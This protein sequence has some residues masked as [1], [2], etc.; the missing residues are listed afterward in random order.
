MTKTARHTLKAAA[1]LALAA[2]KV[3][4]LARKQHQWRQ[5]D[6]AERLGV[7]RQTVARLERGDPS[8]AVGVFL[9]ALWLLDLPLTEGRELPT[10]SLLKLIEQQLPSRVSR[11]KERPIDDDF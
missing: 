1:E 2:G 10:N 11:K 7:T 5:Q 3:L 6:L 8:I 9:S 4:L